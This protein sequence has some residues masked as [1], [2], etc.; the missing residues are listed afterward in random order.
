[1]VLLVICDAFEWNVQGESLLVLLYVYMDRCGGSHIEW[2][3]IATFSWFDCH[4]SDPNPFGNWTVM[5]TGS[6]EICIRTMAVMAVKTMVFISQKF[7]C[8]S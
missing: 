6:A 3:A 1:M 4:F 5:V 8:I 2:C 7:H